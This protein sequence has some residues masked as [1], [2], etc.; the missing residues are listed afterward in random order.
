MTLTLVAG[1]STKIEKQFLMGVFRWSTW[2]SNYRLRSGID[3]LAR[4]LL[5]LTHFTLPKEQ[6]DCRKPEAKTVPNLN[7]VQGTQRCPKNL[8]KSFQGTLEKSVRGDRL[9]DLAVSL[10]FLQEAIN[11]PIGS[12]NSSQLAPIANSAQ[13]ISDRRIS[14]RSSSCS[15]RRSTSSFSRP[16]F[17]KL[18]AVCLSMRIS[19]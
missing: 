1:G 17:R 19:S 5:L 9:V 13:A 11:N 2:S 3:S 12:A 16:S 7:V 6:F 15:I 4:V 8:S 18:T 10:G 14:L